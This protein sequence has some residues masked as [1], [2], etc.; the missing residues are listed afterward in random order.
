M[1][2][3]SHLT[4]LSPEQDNTDTYEHQRLGSNLEGRGPCNARGARPKT[5]LD[6][7]SV[8]RAGRSSYSPVHSAPSS[9]T[10][11]INSVEVVAK[12]LLLLPSQRGL[13]S[14]K[15]V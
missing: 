12:P 11:V 13:H 14:L 4:T 1:L 7:S 5:R 3:A 9:M 15:S 8:L 2:N 6:E 10:P